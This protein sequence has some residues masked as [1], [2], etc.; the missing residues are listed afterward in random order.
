MS[1]FTGCQNVEAVCPDRNLGIHQSDYTVPF[2][3]DYN[4]ESQY[5]A[6]SVCCIATIFVTNKPNTY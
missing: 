3:K 4:F 6:F 1:K 2:P 5:S